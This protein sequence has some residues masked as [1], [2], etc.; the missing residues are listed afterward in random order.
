MPRLKLFRTTIGFH[1]AYVA[2][3]SRKAALAAWG[4]DK[5]LFARE[6][7]E[8]VDDPA[9]LKQLSSSPGQVFRRLRAMPNEQLEA[10]PAS[11][12]AHAKPR[13]A[14]ARRIPKPSDAKVRSA[15]AALARLAKEQE[16]ERAAIAERAARLANDRRALE[17][18]QRAAM[19]EAR[20]EV[21]IAETAYGRAVED[22]RA[23]VKG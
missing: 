6:A 12:A 17:E 18:A 8:Q 11:V 9:L 20:A 19:R 1:D 7:A 15:Q 3:S 23:S 16:A 2:A 10:L 14:K 21:D 13:P 22:W 5:D 4:T